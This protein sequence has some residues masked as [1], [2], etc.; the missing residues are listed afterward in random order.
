[1]TKLDARQMQAWAARWFLEHRPQ[2]V[3]P[4]FLT[5]LL[6]DFQTYLREESDAADKGKEP[7][8]DQQQ[9]PRAAH[10]QDLRE[11]RGE[12]GEGQGE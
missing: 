1:M 7:K 12:Q 5:A 9:H 3:K 4:F 8:H 2:D 10:G 11:D 6:G